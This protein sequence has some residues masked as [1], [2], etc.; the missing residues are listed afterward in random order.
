MLDFKERRNNI[1]STMNVKGDTALDLNEQKKDLNR[2]EEPSRQ[3]QLVVNR[4][5]TEE[6]T[7]DLANVF[8]NMKR[9][10][11]LFAWVLVLCLTVGFCA[12]VLVYQLSKPQLKVSS[13]VTLQYEVPSGRNTMT[14]VS[15]LTAPDG[16]A[17]D[18]NQITSAYVLQTALD[19][20]T[21][22]QPITAANLRS[23]ISI[24]TVLTDES[25]RAQ[26]AM[27]GLADLKNA[28]AYKQLQ[29]IQMK[30]LNR[31]VV[32]LVNG[33]G[34]EESRVKLELKDEELKQ[35]LDRVLTV[36]NDY[37]VKTYA[38]MKLPEDKISVIDIQTLDVLDS[39]DQ[40]RNGIKYLQSYAKEQSDTVRMYRSWQTGRSLQDWMET[41]QTFQT[42]NVDYLYTLVSEN[43]ITRDRDALLTSYKYI[44]RNAQNELKKVNEDIA[45]MQRILE[46][47]KNDEILI[48]MQESDGTK[49]IKAAT[50][51]YNQLM[52]QQVENYDRASEL[53]TTVADYNERILRLEA[54]S[55]EVNETVEAE[56]AKSFE[57]A[58]S[59]YDQISAHMEEIFESPLY[60]TYER[61]SMPQG[62]LQ[63]FLTA[64]VKKIVIG[65]A[66]GGIAACGLWFMAGLLPE[67]SK[68]KKEQES[69]KEAAEK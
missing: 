57:A 56:L 52:L 11:R 17:L 19:G 16:T 55:G 6:V 54:A 41:V 23:N 43:M 58:Q 14:P 3:I 13:V 48:S 5:E 62:K 68:Q 66:L 44:L 24:Q 15:D 36:Y 9:R 63:N 10:R 38:D 47:Y 32:S 4:P 42:I 53:K 28:E 59:L 60:T 45:E 65:V 27:I 64:S 34:D 46:N 21:L 49:T 39:L 25:R 35:V 22:S 51:Y 20:M 12:P 29:S 8:F 33:F 61:H 2:P 7:I 1:Q 40:L 30:Y 67:F 31:F 26:E 18:L 37:L 50:N 69:G